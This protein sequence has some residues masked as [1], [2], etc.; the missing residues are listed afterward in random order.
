ME[1]VHEIILAILGIIEV[2]VWAWGICQMEFTD[3]KK[4]WFVAFII[5]V[6]AR[7]MSF[8]IPNENIAFPIRQCGH[9][10][11]TL[12]IFQG[13]FGKRLIQY[14]F[15]LCYLELIYLPIR[16]LLFGVRLVNEK[17]WL[18]NYQ[19]YILS[20]STILLVAFL[21][22][23]IR[24]H[25]E[26]CNWIKNIPIGYYILGI[27]CSFCA[28]LLG[29]ATRMFSTEWTTELRV[30][31]EVVQAIVMI[32]FYLLGIGFAFV[33]LWKEQYK[34]ENALKDE[35]LKMSQ[36]HYKEL[37]AHM[38]EVR[39]IRHDMKNHM[40]LLQKYIQENNLEQAESYLKEIQQHQQW[41]NKP[42]VSVGNELVNAV[43]SYGIEK[44]NEVKFICE[45]LLPPTMSISDFD[46]CT[47]FSNLL[48]N[49]IEACQRLISREK[50]I[51]LQIKTFQN[52]LLIQMENPVEM[53]VP[54]EKLGTF[55]SKIDKKSHGYGIYNV[56]QTV[57]R[58]N[59]N[60]T[61]LLQNN[62]FYV[63]IQ[64]PF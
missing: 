40:F 2:I 14:W 16:M 5:L 30:V 47:I 38:R 12:L 7:W 6:A 42:V 62:N 9:M 53:E 44:Q 3:K 21:G 4:S 60:I 27:I 55:T 56:K 37:E 59:G 50:Q 31:I 64:I 10:I 39:S 29:T 15:S 51:H 58:N 18:F 52:N 33:N 35:Y 43:L 22:F 19:K 26:V 63:K 28:N 13:K 32:F 23:T 25:K 11:G 54:I 20:I 49:S 24:K 61:F 34:R 46:L 1:I 48:S 17:I 45:G 8:Y 36:E 57:E 41:E